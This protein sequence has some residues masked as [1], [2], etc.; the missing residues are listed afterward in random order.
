[1]IKTNN[2]PCGSIS[3][4]L[5]VCM[6]GITQNKAQYILYVSLWMHVANCHANR[7]HPHVLTNKEPTSPDIYNKKVKEEDIWLLRFDTLDWIRSGPCTWEYGIPFQ[8]TCETLLTYTVDG[9]GTDLHRWTPC[10]VASPA[11]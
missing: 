11:V 6:H 10:Q 8:W 5:R 7:H 3:P 4:A 2:L 9:S 1:M